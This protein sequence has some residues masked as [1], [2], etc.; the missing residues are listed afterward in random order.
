MPFAALITNDRGWAEI[1]CQNLFITN[2]L[3]R[4]LITPHPAS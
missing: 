2:G 4:Y 1:P 3:L